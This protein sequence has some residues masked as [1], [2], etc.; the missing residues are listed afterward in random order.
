MFWS[1]P[2]RF[3]D[4]ILKI[5]VGGRPGKDDDIPIYQ[6]PRDKCLEVLEHFCRIFQEPPGLF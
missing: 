6:S 3:L 5:M 2:D 4:F 1:P